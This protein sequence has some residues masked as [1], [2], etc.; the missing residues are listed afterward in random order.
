[1]PLWCFAVCC[2]AYGSELGV[3]E[4]KRVIVVAGGLLIFAYSMGCIKG[5][6]H[7]YRDGRTQ[8]LVE[9]QGEQK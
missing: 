8:A 2:D 1:M 6:F 5:Y 4:S 9:I 3:S 7:G